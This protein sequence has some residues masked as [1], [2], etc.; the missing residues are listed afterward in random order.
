MVFYFMDI[1]IFNKL[2]EIDRICKVNVLLIG[3]II[4]DF[5]F[6]LFNIFIRRIFIIIVIF[7]FDERFLDDKI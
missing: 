7:N 2:G 4:E 6:I 5:N 3:V 1:G